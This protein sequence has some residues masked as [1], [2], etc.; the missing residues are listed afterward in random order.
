MQDKEILEGIPIQL[1]EPIEEVVLVS[2][3]EIEDTD[4]TL[5]DSEAAQVVHGMTYVEAE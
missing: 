3:E 2:E 5:L 4:E 1:V